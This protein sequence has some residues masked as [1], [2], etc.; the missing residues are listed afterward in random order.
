MYSLHC[1]IGTL[2]HE[3]V[4]LHHLKATVFDQEL[5]RAMPGEQSGDHQQHS[6]DQPEG[7]A[8]PSDIGKDAGLLGLTRHQA[9]SRSLSKILSAACETEPAPSVMT[10]SPG[11]AAAAMAAMPS[12]IVGV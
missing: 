6:G 4:G 12:S 9:T 5:F 3:V 11:W 2:A 10:R 8:A 7:K 1:Q